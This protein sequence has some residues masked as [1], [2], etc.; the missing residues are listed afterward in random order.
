MGIIVVGSIRMT[1]LVRNRD[2]TLRNPRLMTDSLV[3]VLVG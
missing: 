3:K 2:R 1:L